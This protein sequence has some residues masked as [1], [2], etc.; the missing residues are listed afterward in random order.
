MFN[1]GP[2]NSGKISVSEFISN[3]IQSGKEA[4]PIPISAA[5]AI[6]E[7]LDTSNT[8]F[9]GF[10]SSLPMNNS[11]FNLFLSRGGCAVSP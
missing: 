1:S 3:S 5:L 6:P 7:I 11:Q 8:D 9:L 2:L 10:L 4:I